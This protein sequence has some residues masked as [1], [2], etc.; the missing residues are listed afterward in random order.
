MCSFASQEAFSYQTES[1]GILISC[2]NRSSDYDSS[3]P[4]K[5]ELL[6]SSRS[7]KKSSTYKDT[8]NFHLKWKRITIGRQ[9]VK[10]HSRMQEQYKQVKEGL[11]VFSKWQLLKQPYGS[12][13]FL[14]T[15]FR[16]RKRMWR[17]KLIFMADWL[18]CFKGYVPMCLYAS[19]CAHSEESFKVLHKRA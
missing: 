9:S 14:G 5:G 11:S 17:I 4:G 12:L 7:F 10:R 15:L 2:C 13:G 19:V 16:K 1:S 18:F 6:S 3:I 8:F